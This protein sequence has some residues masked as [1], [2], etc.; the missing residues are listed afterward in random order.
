MQK[1]SANNIEEFA[2]HVSL[3]VI[4]YDIGVLSS[5]VLQLY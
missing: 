3:D 5:V 1:L 2:V 4:D